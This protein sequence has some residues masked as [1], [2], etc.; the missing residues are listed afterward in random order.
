ME[1]VSTVPGTA[2]PPSNSS[3]W[4]SF[5]PKAQ[6]PPF[7]FQSIFCAVVR[8]VFLNYGS[9]IW[10]WPQL[11]RGALLWLQTLVSHR[12]LLRPGSLGLSIEL[13]GLLYGR[14]PAGCQPAP[15]GL[16]VAPQPPNQSSL[17]L[18]LGGLTPESHHLAVKSCLKSHLPWEASPNFPHHVYRSGPF[19][20]FR[21]GIY[22][23]LCPR[24]FKSCS[25]SSLH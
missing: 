7:P 25:Y 20:F 6:V 13:R 24:V 18:V 4:V 9:V 21:F 23:T 8:S 15:T 17:F 2:G 11:F 10:H 14:H 16:F 22:N 19:S 1:A 5:A 12:A 3:H